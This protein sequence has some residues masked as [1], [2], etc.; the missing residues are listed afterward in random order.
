MWTAITL[1]I[2]IGAGVVA[3]GVGASQAVRAGAPVWPWIV[4]VPGLYLGGVRLLT[5]T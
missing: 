5:L 4:A 3:L 1:W 2:V